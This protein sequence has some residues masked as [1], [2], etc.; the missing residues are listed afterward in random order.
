MSKHSR[1]DREREMDELVEKSDAKYDNIKTATEVA[2]MVLLAGSV[3]TGAIIGTALSI[4]LGFGGFLLFGGLNIA[5]R[6]FI[7]AKK[8]SARREIVK[9]FKEDGKQAENSKEEILERDRVTSEQLDMMHQLEIDEYE[10][11]KDEFMIGHEESIYMDRLERRMDKQLFGRHD[12]E[13]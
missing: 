9:S 4:G 12:I 10:R 3:A 1:N 6:F 8:T 5:S 13:R 11:N 7:E 2:S